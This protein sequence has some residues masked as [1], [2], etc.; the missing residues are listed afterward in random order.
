MKLKYVFV[1]LFMTLLFGITAY[2]IIFNPIVSTSTVTGNCT[3]MDFDN[4]RII[5]NGPNGGLAN[6]PVGDW[7]QVRLGGHYLYYKVDRLYGEDEVFFG[8]IGE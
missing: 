7:D 4:A 5:L 8:K 1:T 6:V 2:I 3:S